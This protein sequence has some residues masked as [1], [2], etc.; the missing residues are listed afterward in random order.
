[1]VGPEAGPD[2]PELVRRIHLASCQH[3]PVPAFV[4]CV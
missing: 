4:V 2:V 1:M 3:D